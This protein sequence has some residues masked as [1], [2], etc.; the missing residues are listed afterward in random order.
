MNM[1]ANF[2][3]TPGKPLVL[4][5]I[6][7]TSETGLFAVCLLVGDSDVTLHGQTAQNVR[8]LAHA[9][10]AAMD[11]TEAKLTPAALRASRG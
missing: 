8:D 10:L 5:R 9:M 3:P 1:F 2:F 7:P 4:R 6:A 11:E